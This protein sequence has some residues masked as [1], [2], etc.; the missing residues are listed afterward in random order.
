AAPWR[1]IEK[2]KNTIAPC[3]VVYIEN[4][5][6]QTTEE[7][8]TA[9]ISMDNNGVSNSGTAA[10]PKALIAYPNASVTV[11][12]AGGLHYGIRTP[13]IGTNEDYWVISQLHIVGGTQAMDIGG[14]GWRII[15]NEMQ[16]PGADD[17]VGCFEMSEGTQTKF[18]GNEVHNAGIN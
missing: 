6:A 3:D 10:A 17:Q 5:V 1:T 14:A 7:N 9:Y 2:A 4:G 16:C 13:N 15:G 11:G 18:Y 8:F 12:V